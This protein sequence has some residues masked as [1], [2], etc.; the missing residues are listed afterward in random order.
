MSFVIDKSSKKLRLKWINLIR[1]LNNFEEASDLI[2]KKLKEEVKK[3]ELKILLDHTRLC[4]EIPEIY[5][6][7]S[8]QEKIYSK[9]TDIILSEIFNYF[10]FKTKVLK[11]R[12]DSADVDIYFKKKDLSFVADAK[13]FR[14][15]RTAKNAKDFKVQSMAKW[16][17][18]KPFA[19]L[20]CPSHQLPTNKSQIYSQAIDGD[21]CIITFTHL[22]II[23]N[24]KKDNN[25]DE[26]QNLFENIFLSIKKLNS[27]Q[28][29]NE[30]WRNINSIIKN[31]SKDVL[32]I[33]NKEKELTEE[34]IKLSKE[35]A[36]FHYNILIKNIKKLSHKQAIDKLIEPY[37]NQI[38]EVQS[39]ENNNILNIK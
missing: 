26:I 17:K 39:L 32:D 20:V 16:K 6:L 11:A 4:S 8:T 13:V 5:S 10:G 1:K 31:F 2:E 18:G 37:N 22:A 3:G 9:Y 15:S 35:I 33:W 30:Y 7:N 36:L 23:L 28:S 29:A 34:S 21:V 19:L 27:S 24:L 12:G 38:K 14:A 25:E